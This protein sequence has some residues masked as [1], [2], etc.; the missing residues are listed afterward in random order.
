VSNSTDKKKALPVLLPIGLRPVHMS[1]KYSYCK[2]YS[3]K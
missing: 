2:N 3:C 1:Y